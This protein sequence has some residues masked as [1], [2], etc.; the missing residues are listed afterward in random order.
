M[1]KIIINLIT[2]IN[3]FF[4]KK[5]FKKIIFFHTPQSAGNS[6]VYFFKLNF[7]FR[8]HI[9]EKEDP[10]IDST[11]YEKYLYLSG[12]FGLDRMKSVK[13]RSE[14]FYMFSIREPKKRYLSNYYRNLDLHTKENKTY[15][16]LER[17]LELRLSGNY[18]N[19]YTRYLSGEIINGDENKINDQ[20]FKVALNNLEKINFFFILERSL[21]CFEKLKK[22]LN[23]FIPF[24]NFFILHKN[25]V[26]GSKYPELTDKEKKLLEELTLYD[27]Q[28][29]K[30]ILD[31]H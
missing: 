8:G 7:G 14:Y 5:K 26:S 18:D 25:K 20:I 13:F 21:M 24:S 22:K 31:N 17:F 11:F 2:S 9:L 29:Y 12:H 10:I 28:I 15:M 1:K 4:F 6:I 23:I 30:K 27:S 16:T 3:V 19:Y